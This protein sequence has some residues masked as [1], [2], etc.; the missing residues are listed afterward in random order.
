MFKLISQ[1]DRPYS[2]LTLSV[3]M[4]GVRA[5]FDDGHGYCQSGFD[6]CRRAT[7]GAFEKTYFWARPSTVAPEVLEG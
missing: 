6:P 5:S 1:I 2:V 4:S 3:L 7:S